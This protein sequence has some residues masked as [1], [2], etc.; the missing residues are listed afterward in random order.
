MHSPTLPTHQRG[1]AWPWPH[2]A[3]ASP[4][5]HCATASPL[6]AWLH[7]SSVQGDLAR[8]HPRPLVNDAVETIEGDQDRLHVMADG[9]ARDLVSQ[10]LCADRP[11]AP[12]AHV[13]LPAMKLRKIPARYIFLP[14]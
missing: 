1:R 14:A 2:R 5:L 4:H 10:L 6:A 8:L 12:P 11:M 13:V 7:S 9:D 3:T